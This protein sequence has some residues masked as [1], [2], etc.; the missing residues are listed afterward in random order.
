MN[1]VT[2]LHD[3][4]QKPAPEKWSRFSEPVSGAFV[5]GISFLHITVKSVVEPYS[6]QSYSATLK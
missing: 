5:M 3:T 6:G 4:Y 2:D 1:P